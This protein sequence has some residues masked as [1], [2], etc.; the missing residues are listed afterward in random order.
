MGEILLVDIKIF[1]IEVVPNKTWNGSENGVC[2]CPYYEETSTVT[3]H[4]LFCNMLYV[5]QWSYVK[6]MGAILLVV[7]KIFTTEV[8]SQNNWMWQKIC[9]FVKSGVC[10]PQYHEKTSTVTCYF[11]FANMLSMLQRSYVKSLGEILLVDIKIF[12]QKLSQ[13]GMQY[14][15]NRCK[16]VSML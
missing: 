1:L 3:H 10:L 6:N 4:F 11:L 13:K 12:Q 8:G 15:R 7:I 5:L 16:F 9:N 2:L 14:L